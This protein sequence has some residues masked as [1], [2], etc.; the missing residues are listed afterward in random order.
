MGPGFAALGA[1][2]ITIAGYLARG[3]TPP[4]AVFIGAGIAGVALLTLASASPEL[5][6]RFGTL[7]LLTALL[8]SGADV[9]RGVS[10]AVGSSKTSDA[11]A[12]DAL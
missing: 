8:T 2:G 9:A 10:R 11:P 4:P 3:R 1:G 5:A 7:V 6:S 12:P